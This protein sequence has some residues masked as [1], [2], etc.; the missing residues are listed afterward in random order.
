MSSMKDGGERA[1]TAQ[2]GAALSQRK[3]PASKEPKDEFVGAFAD[4]LRD[5]LEDERP[6]AA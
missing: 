2:E 3:R 4:A 6:R 1:P 5:I